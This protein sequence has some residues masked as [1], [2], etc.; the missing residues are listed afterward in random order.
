MNYNNIRQS[1][2][3]YKVLVVCRESTKDHIL[4]H[5]DKRIEEEKD[6]SCFSI[7]DHIKQ[8]IITYADQ[9]EQ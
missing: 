6:E 4:M 2:L 7:Y 5:L 1:T 3:Y 8:Y 9:D